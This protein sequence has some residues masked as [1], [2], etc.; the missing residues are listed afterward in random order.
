MYG[1]Y[2]GSKLESYILKLLL[3][4]FCLYSHSIRL[5]SDKIPPL[6]FTAVEAEDV[7][8]LGSAINI[9]S[10]EKIKAQKVSL[11]TFIDVNN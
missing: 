5:F 2:R 3:P 11:V 4:I 1:S 9:L 7:K 6:F 8:R 10:T